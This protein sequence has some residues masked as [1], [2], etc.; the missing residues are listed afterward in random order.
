[1]LHIGIDG[2]KKGAISVLDNEG[3]IK[4][5]WMMPLI[6][7]KKAQYDVQG[8]TDCFTHLKSCYPHLKLQ[9]V[10]EMPII[11]RMNGKIAVASTST[12]GKFYHVEILSDGRIVCDCNGFKYSYRYENPERRNK[13]THTEI[14]R[15]IVSGHNCLYIRKDLLCSKHHKLRKRKLPPKEGDYPHQD[16]ITL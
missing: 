5:I 9:A 10:L 16:G 12:P 4:H 6:K 13:C 2:G 3:N 14:V 15:C 1:M 7:G 8:I 11:N